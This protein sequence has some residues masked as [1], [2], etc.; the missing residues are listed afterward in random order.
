MT[1]S[2]R[3]NSDIYVMDLSSRST[4]RLTTDPAIDVSASY[5]PT[6]RDIVFNSDRGGS[7]QLYTMRS[8]GSNVKRISFG[9]GRYSAPV[10]SPRGDLIAFVKSQNGQFSIGVMNTDGSG[11]RI[12]TTSYLDEGPT[13]SPNGRVILFSRESQGRNAKSEVWSIDLSGR[14][15]RK[16][17]TPGQASDPAWSPILP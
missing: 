15:L 5:A 13:W 7:P 9:K 2:R 14:N 3:G 1:L 8:D 16:M 12:L 10:W 4:T 11:E 17:P 6:G